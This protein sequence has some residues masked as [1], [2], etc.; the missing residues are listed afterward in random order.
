[1]IT[2]LNGEAGVAEFVGRGE[3][4]IAEL[5]AC[6]P[7]FLILLFA[8]VQFA[9]WSHAE[10]LAQAAAQEG[11]QAGSYLGAGPSDAT[12]AAYSFIRQTGPGLL[13]G[14]SVSEGSAGTAGSSVSVTVKGSV[15][16]L[17]PFLH[18]RVSATSVSA[19]QGYVPSSGAPGSAPVSQG[20]LSGA[21]GVPAA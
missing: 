21:A 7:V 14:A 20:P 10:H 15:Q 19:V 1:M 9:L 12:A 6:I 11:S 16:S 4:G 17:V 13:R 2:D 18:L 3:S 8:G 5:V